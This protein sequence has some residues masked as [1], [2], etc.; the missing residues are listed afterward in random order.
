MISYFVNLL[1]HFLQTSIVYKKISIDSI[2]EMCFSGNETN[3]FVF[4]LHWFRPKPLSLYI[5]SPSKDTRKLLVENTSSGGVCVNETLF[6]AGGNNT[7]I[8]FLYGHVFA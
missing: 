2:I 3:L 4:L 8:K 1:E 6:H 7:L 5:F